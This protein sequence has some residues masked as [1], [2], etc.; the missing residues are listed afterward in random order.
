M[1][2]IHIS[3]LGHATLSIFV[4]SWEYLMHKE[5]W[6]AMN[7]VNDFER[8]HILTFVSQLRIILQ[9]KSVLL[10]VL[11]SSSTP[12]TI[13]FNPWIYFLNKEQVAYKVY[14]SFSPFNLEQYHHPFYRSITLLLCFERFKGAQ[15]ELR[16]MIS[17]T[18]IID[19]HCICW[20]VSSSVNLTHL[21]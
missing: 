9:S 5:K 19:E 11:T 4:E 18:H 1:L 2:L 16:E 17:S 8:T 20:I 14:M 3:V 15:R 7:Y 10:S 12:C 21:L 13:Q 6:Y